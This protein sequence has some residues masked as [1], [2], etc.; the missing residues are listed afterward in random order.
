MKSEKHD[1]KKEAIVVA[2]IALFVKKG[3]EKTT[4]SDILKE[5]GISKGTFYHYFSSKDDLLKSIILIINQKMLE[6]MDGILA[7]ESLDAPGK[8]RAW[9]SHEQSQ[10]NAQKDLMIDFM[11]YIY[12]EHNLKL[13]KMCQDLIIHQLTPFFTRIIEQGNGEGTMQVELPEH[14]AFL[15]THLGMGVRERSVEKILSGQAT[16]DWLQNEIRS[17]ELT[18]ERILATEPGQIRLYDEGYIASYIDD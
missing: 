5:A 4:L 6:P 17:Y 9:F 16:P 7:D 18:V 3:M 8:F 14:T 13:R 2:S 10:K 12:S 15:I 1:K 11:K